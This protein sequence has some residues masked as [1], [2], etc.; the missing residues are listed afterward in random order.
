MIKAVIFDLNGVFIKS[1]FLSKRLH[2]QYNISEE[3]FVDALKQVMPSLR[4]PQNKNSFAVWQPYLQ[5]LGLNLSEKEFF[6]FWFGGEQVDQDLINY[7]AELR[8]A[9]KKVYVLSNNFRER[10]LH[11]RERYPGLFQNLDGAYFSWETGNIN[12]SDKNI[13]VASSLG[14]HAQKYLGLEETKKT[15]ESFG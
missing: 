1:D 6:D 14:I 8:Q 15:V 11:Y 12:D 5:N 4:S 3:A 2:S 13:E 7:A 10:T 9:G